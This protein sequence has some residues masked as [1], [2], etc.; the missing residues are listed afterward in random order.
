MIPARRRQIARLEKLAAPAI[1]YAR[2]QYEA[3]T[4]RLKDHAT[5]HA[6]GLG[7]LVLYGKPNL[8]E[9]LSDAW[10]R[11]SERFPDL[12]RFLKAKLSSPELQAMTIADIVRRDVL[13][14][15]PGSSE[16]EKF[17][18]LFSSAPPWLLWFT[19]ADFTAYQLGLTLP[20]LSGV[21]N[22]GRSKKELMNWPSLPDYK[23][24]LRPPLPSTSLDISASG[25]CV[26][27]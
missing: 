7:A 23:F 24:E 12:E 2:Q 18:S 1:E 5:L 16:K 15:L 3:L 6:I 8:Q 10:Q 11:C 26:L 19:F 13:S 27:Y 17:Q 22:F 20:D 14:D 21:T 9:P 25:C 4:A